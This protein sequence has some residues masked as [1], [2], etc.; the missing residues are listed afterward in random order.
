MRFI[1]ETPIYFSMNVEAPD[2][3]TAAKAA[4]DFIREIAPVTSQFD[5]KKGKA[6][7]V[8]NQVVMVDEDGQPDIYMCRE[9]YIADLN[10]DKYDETCS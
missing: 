2:V 8:S 6:R 10:G 1:V 3:A 5:V 4:A 9:G 7:I